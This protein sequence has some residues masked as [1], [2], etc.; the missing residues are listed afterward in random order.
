MDRPL[1]LFG[2][3]PRNTRKLVF[4]ATGQAD[5]IQCDMV[6]DL[7]LAKALG[8][9]AD[10]RTQWAWQRAYFLIGEHNRM[11]Q[12]GVLT[13]LKTLGKTYGITIPYRNEW[14]R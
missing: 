2:R 10:I 13:E 3:V 12:P 1:V 8:G 11:K 4:Q 6:F 7:D 14:G 9:E 5:D